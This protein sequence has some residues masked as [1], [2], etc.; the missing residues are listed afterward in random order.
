MRNLNYEKLPEGL[1][2]GAQL[3]LERGIR[4]GGFLQACFEDKLV[5]A[6]SRADE[7]NAL[8][9]KDIAYWLYNYCPAQA[10]GSE[11]LVQAWIDK[12]GFEGK[13]IEGEKL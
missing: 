11:E 7:N 9:L 8:R 10:R 5:G 12:G 2:S 13:E 1:Q 3:Y 4:P 6:Y